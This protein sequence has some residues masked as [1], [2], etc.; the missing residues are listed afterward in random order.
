MESIIESSYSIELAVRVIKEIQSFKKS[1][2]NQLIA[3]IE[4]LL[5]ELEK[6]PFEGTGKPERLKGNLTN[7]WSRRINLE[8]RLIYVV[9]S[10]I[11]YVKQVKGHY[12]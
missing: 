9:I 10:N 11:V 2:Q 8:H 5:N 12:K 7:H 1:G 4:N 6:H 3:K